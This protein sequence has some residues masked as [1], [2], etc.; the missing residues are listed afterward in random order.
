MKMTRRLLALL[1]STL[2]MFSCLPAAPAHADEEE[3]PWD[4]L[5]EELL[6]ALTDPEPDSRDEIQEE[7]LKLDS[8]V[9]DLLAACWTELFLEPDYHLNLHG[10]DD[11]ATLPVTGSHAFVVLGYQLQNNQMADELKGRC[12]AAAA[13][14]KAFPDS[15]IICTGG[16]T[17]SDES[18]T[19]AGLMKQYLTDVHGI[20]PER[21]FAE[22]EARSTAENALYSFGL[23]MLLNRDSY[24]IITSDYHQRRAIMLFETT[25]A[26]MEESVA[27]SATLISNYCYDTGSDQEKLMREAK[28]T[29]RQLDSVL[30]YAADRQTTEDQ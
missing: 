30:N 12:D 24:T 19:E 10:K 23:M 20:A 25:S 15:V 28:T 7:L 8:Q 16:S 18:I 5:L 2:L 6:D 29:I 21:V 11:P 1:L 3:D 17:G 4:D 22:E 13:A 14:A 9:Y 26:L 27:F